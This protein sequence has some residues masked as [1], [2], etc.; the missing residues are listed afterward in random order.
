M[1]HCRPPWIL[2]GMWTQVHIFGCLECFMWRPKGLQ[3]YPLVSQVPNTYP[4]KVLLNSDPCPSLCSLLGMMRSKLVPKQVW[5]NAQRRQG[6]RESSSIY[7]SGCVHNRP[8]WL[9]TYVHV[10]SREILVDHCRPLRDRCWTVNTST[11]LWALGMLYVKTQRFTM[12]SCGISG[13]QHL[14]I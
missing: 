1:D 13:S 5:R 11:Y 12:V 4:Y 9:F 6:P 10:S 3:W 2:V 7:K 14:S 8:A